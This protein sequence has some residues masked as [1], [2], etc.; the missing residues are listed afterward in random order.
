MSEAAAVVWR[1]EDL[2]TRVGASERLDVRDVRHLVCQMKVQ[3]AGLSALKCIPDDLHPDVLG[4]D[5]ADLLALEHEWQVATLLDE[6][7]EHLWVEVKHH[8]DVGVV[9]LL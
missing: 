8:R 2:T 5:R 1:H 6:L 7:E 9:Q 3:D 4:R